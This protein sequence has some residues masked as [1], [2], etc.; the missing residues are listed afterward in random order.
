MKRRRCTNRGAAGRCKRPARD[1]FKWCVEC[2]DSH[3]KASAAYYARQY[4][5]G[6]WVQKRRMRKGF[7]PACCA[8]GHRDGCKEMRRAA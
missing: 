2:A 6:Y 5:P 7:C 8:Y 1:G 3:R 4:F